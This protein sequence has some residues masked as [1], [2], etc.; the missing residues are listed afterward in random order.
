MP[1]Y[2]IDPQLL[3]EFIDESEES[4]SSLD[5][6]FV[7]LESN[8]ENLELVNEI[9]RPVHSL[10]GNSAFFGLL[11]TKEIAHKM[12]NVL[13]LIR[14]GKLA[15][16]SDIIGA[17]LPGLDLLKAMLG[18]TRSGLPETETEDDAH[19]REILDRIIK[20]SDT[21][22]SQKEVQRQ[23]RDR[24]LAVA[25]LSDSEKN[26]LADE[27][28]TII[29]TGAGE[30]KQ[31]A[32]SKDLPAELKKIN[33]ILAEPFENKL[34]DENSEKVIEYL[35]KLRGHSEDGQTIKL[36]ED[37]I[38]E[39]NTMVNAV[40]FD[41][42]LRELVLDKTGELVKTGVWK[43][44]AGSKKNTEKQKKKKD[45]PKSKEPE[46]TMR[47][48]EKSIDS[49][50]A[51]VGELVVVE[52]MFGYLQ[53]NLAAT[54]S[55][56]RMVTE[57]RRIIENFSSL[58]DDLQKSIMAI[59]KVPV[60]SILQKVPRTIRD[61]ADATGKKVTVRLEGE[62][63]DVD[64]SHI[65]TLDSPLTHIV[66]NAIDHGIELPEERKAAGKNEQGE[67][68]VSVAENSND[69]VLTVRDDGKGIDYEAVK[70]KAVSLGLISAESSLSN[71][72]IVNVLF[73]PGVSTAKEV[74]DIS[75]RG[76]GM[77]VVKRNIE[78]AGG[79]IQIE[80][81]KGKGSV[82]KIMLPKSVSTQ[83]VE[84][85][86]VKAGKETYVLPL[87]RIRE[88]FVP[89]QSDLS[90][91]TG[92][93]EIVVRRGRIMP[94]VRLTSIF[95]NKPQNNRGKDGAGE[96]RQIMVAVEVKDK[97]YAFCVDSLVG[98][99]KVVVKPIKG[100]NAKSNLFE[101]GAMMGDGSV[102]MIIGNE[103]IKALTETRN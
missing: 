50:L 99:Q 75:G 38:D 14:Q 93:G 85:F 47:V 16:S 56:R 73:A 76:V 41:S 40:G 69:I 10:K 102:A 80:S 79:T 64:K 44:A 90:T 8:P 19:Y 29:S 91:V 7:E 39:Y 33:D 22:A 11:K 96:F 46:K 58:S 94:I 98:V 95:G 101:G 60:R 92:K 32:D 63:T 34:D 57:L 78:A 55:D 66:R 3:A 89:Q 83:I 45:V 6:L 18:N 81:E 52:E 26:T 30:E 5:N 97:M 43:K 42:L 13:D 54:S 23:I 28:L 2:Q 48:P 77:D 24:L 35:Q 70:N 4:L 67:I 71:E 21:N 65:G 20:A 53:K 86:L 15:A 68:V 59:R 17:L 1:E 37:A 88:S 27:I 49:F 74:T 36:I 61:I 12:E 87:N 72:D 51:Y 82:F 25:S 9:F 31:A 62:D 103:G 100:L 84:G